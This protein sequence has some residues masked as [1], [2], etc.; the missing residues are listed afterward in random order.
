MSVLKLRVYVLV[1]DLC[2][3]GPMLIQ[4]EISSI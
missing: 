4:N 1:R 3:F 2:V